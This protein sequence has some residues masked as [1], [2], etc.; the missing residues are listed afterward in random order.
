MYADDTSVYLAG[1]TV[2]FRENTLNEEL[3]G[4][5]K[6]C[7]QNHL[8]VNTVKTKCILICSAQERRRLHENTL[9]LFNIVWGTNTM[10]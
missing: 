2:T 3:H 9:Q 6:W 7:N 8:V 4:I 10:C 1:P 5:E